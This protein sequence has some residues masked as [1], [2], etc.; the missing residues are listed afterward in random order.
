MREVTGQ[1]RVESINGDGSSKLKRERHGRGETR[2]A[3]TWFCLPV[4][5]QRLEGHTAR[6]R[7]P[8]GRRRRGHREVGDGNGGSRLG[9]TGLFKLRGPSALVG[10][11]RRMMKDLG[12]LTGRKAEMGWGGCCDWADAG[13]NKGNGLGQVKGFRA[14]IVKRIGWL[15]KCLLN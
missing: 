13:E 11:G 6:Q 14:E 1:R 10:Y 3:V 9:R 7:W 8:N 15:Q 12:R 2:E 5:R 4:V